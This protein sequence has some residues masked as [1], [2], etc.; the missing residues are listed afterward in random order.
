MLP[1]H[2]KV[3]GESPDWAISESLKKKNITMNMV[4]RVK[5]DGIVADDPE[6]IIGVF[7]NNH[8]PLSVA[9]LNVDNTAN[10]NEPLA[11]I[12]VYNNNLEQQPLHFEYYDCTT[13]RISVLKR[14]DGEPLVFLADTLLGT[15]KDP[16]MLVNSGEEVQM[17]HLKKGWNWVSFEMKPEKNTISNLLNRSTKWEGGDAVEVL[18]TNGFY[19]ISYK[20]IPNPDNPTRINYFWDNGNDSIELDATRMYRIYSCSDKTA[21]LSG[22][23]YDDFI[24]VSPGW[25]R[26]AYISHL[27]LPIANALADYTAK[28]TVGDIIKSQSEFSMLVEDTQGNRMWKGTLTHLTVGQGYML[29]HLGNNDFI[30]YYPSYEGSTRYGSVQYKAPRYENNTG[31]SMNIVARTA[32]VDLQ[33]GDCLVAY[34]GAELCGVAEKSDDDLFFLSVA[35]YGS[36]DLS[37]AIQRGEELI[38][39]SSNQ[40]TY[41]T[42]GVIGTVNEPT[43]I[44]FAEVS[45]QLIGEW[46][47]LQ[48]RQI[49]NSKLSKGLYIHNGQVVVVK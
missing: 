36:N 34:N 41:Q 19:E 44:N 24:Q 46:Y 21:Y 27:N 28:A 5:I 45:H 47:D 12:T 7:G 22:Q 48:G 15:T 18:G 29:K 8:E 37:F 4:A 3:R 23:R 6:D 2:I 39:L 32:G 20:G 14:E 13:G 31:S 11:F 26:I 40:M 38:A 9:H 33:E 30:F 43:V 49:S 1:I 16:I 35:D 10:A 42:N 17:M 25:N